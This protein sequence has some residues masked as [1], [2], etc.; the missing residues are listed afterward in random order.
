MMAITKEESKKIK[1]LAQEGKQTKR[2]VEDH[3]PHLAYG[4]V[5]REVRDWGERSA[6]GRQREITRKINIL[7]SCDNLAERE[8]MAKEIQKLVR[9]MYYAYKSSHDKLSTIR[10]ALES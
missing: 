7:T 9:D 10:E 8:R 4:E 6:L 5:A 2:I 1:Q 3:F